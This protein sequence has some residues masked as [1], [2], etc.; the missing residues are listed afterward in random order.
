MSSREDKTSASSLAAMMADGRPRREPKRPQVNRGSGLIYD[1]IL[2]I[3]SCTLIHWE[4]ALT[5]DSDGRYIL[6]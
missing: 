5:L 1:L 3:L 2:W 4:S 6:S